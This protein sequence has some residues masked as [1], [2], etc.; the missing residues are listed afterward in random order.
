MLN[1]KNFI[2]PE[3]EAAL[4]NLEAIPGFP[5]VAKKFLQLGYERLKYGINMASKIRL[6]P[7]QL[8]D[9]YNR[10][11]PICKKMGI[12]EPEFY[13]EM[14]PQPN[15]CTFGDTQI[16]IAVTSGLFDYLDN[17]EVN[18]VIAHECGHIVCRHVLYHTMAEM[19][20]SGASALG[21]LG[22][23]IKPFEYALLYWYRK[24][25]L[26][27]DRAA[28]LVLGV[29]EVVK[30][31]VRL[32]GGHKIITS[33]INLEEWAQQADK[34]EEIRSGKTWDKALQT[35][36]IMSQTHPFSAVRVREILRWGESEQ[37]KRLKEAMERNESGK[38]CPN[39]HQA[40]SD[41][42]VF[43]KNCGLKI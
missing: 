6:S 21:M 33:G 29:D 40:I 16:Y 5:T 1:P 4:R 12:A 30:T 15:A 22:A 36:A 9:I 28:A 2:H 27:A 20:I 26:S 23:L 34:Y 8:P 10:L 19:V 17:N 24:S 35:L 7:T 31:H 37:Y 11:P 43:C 3:D 13:L 42:W 38:V 14:S 18:S 32:A 41:D 39:C 25:E